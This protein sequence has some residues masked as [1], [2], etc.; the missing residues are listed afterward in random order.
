MQI[1]RGRVASQDQ[2]LLDQW[3]KKFIENYSLDGDQSRQRIELDIEA[4]ELQLIF[5]AG[6][7]QTYFR[8][9]SLESNYD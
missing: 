6:R 2:I 1:S 5:D 4:E 8:R 9:R 7:Y 3:M